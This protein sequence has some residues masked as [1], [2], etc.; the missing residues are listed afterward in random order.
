MTSRTPPTAPPLLEFDNVTVYRG[1]KKVLDSLS[2][3][4]REG[5]NVAILGPNGAGKSSFIKTIT[6]EYN[7]VVAVDGF[8]FRM[9]G[10]EVWDVFELR[11]FL[12]VVSNDLQYT[13]MRELPGREVILSGFFSSIGLFNHPVTAKMED[14]A[15]RIVSFLE[16]D[17]LQ[18][19]PM[20]E[21]SSEK[22]GVF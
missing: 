4:I 15:D 12:G 13:F 1:D 3:T 8:T 2:V 17:H 7:P 6:R 16:I 18:E 9:R 20:T 22:P 19:K 11:S 14:K 10:R 21:M 5:E